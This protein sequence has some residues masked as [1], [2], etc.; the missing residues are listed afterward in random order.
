MLEIVYINVY[1]M[2]NNPIV[3]P[4][5]KLNKLN[6]FVTY[7]LLAEA[8]VGTFGIPLIKI[9]KNVNFG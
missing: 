3:R 4:G 7:C 8:K 6:N 5:R 9:T 2:V 1:T